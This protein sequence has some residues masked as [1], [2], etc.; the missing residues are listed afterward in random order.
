MKARTV[1]LLLSA[2]VVFYFL[3][4]GDRGLTMVKDGR[5]A[6]VL[7]GI[8][9][10]LLPVVGV[11]VLWHELS[12][13]SSTQ[14]LSAELETEGGLPV[15]DLPRTEKGRIDRSAADAAFA[16]RKTEVEAAPE[17][18]RS[19]FRLAVAY[20]DAGDT[21]RGRRAM[22]A[23]IRLHSAKAQAGRD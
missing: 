7:L 17:D 21:A 8:G 6:F 4:L 18:W 10:L 23:A 16:V 14:R 20:G 2:V 22:R 11:W 3:V 12:F 9:V 1:A 5:P 19:W 15:D 13:G